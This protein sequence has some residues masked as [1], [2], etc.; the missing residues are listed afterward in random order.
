MRPQNGACRARNEQCLTLPGKDKYKSKAAGQWIKASQCK[1]VPP[2]G[3][4][5][6]PPQLTAAGSRDKQTHEGDGCQSPHMTFPP[7]PA[8]LPE[9]RQTAPESPSSPLARASP[10]RAW[11]GEHPSVLLP[12]HPPAVRG[13]P[14]PLRSS[15]S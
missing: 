4:W 1:C 7:V 6:S 11:L 8:D 10:D 3:P 15:F 13:Y 14:Q 12:H 9:V 2:P 5:L